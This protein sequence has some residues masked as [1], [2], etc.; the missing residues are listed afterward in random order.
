[1]SKDI[2]EYVRRGI[3][4]DCRLVRG[5][6]VRRVCGLLARAEGYPHRGPSPSPAT[7]SLNATEYEDAEG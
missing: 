1:M 6:I 4:R 7:E 3:R 2:E 5:W